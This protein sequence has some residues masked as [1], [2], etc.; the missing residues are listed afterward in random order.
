MTAQVIIGIVFVLIGICV[1]VAK[2]AGMLGSGEIGYVAEVSNLGFLLLGKEL[3]NKSAAAQAKESARKSIAPVAIVLLLALLPACAW[4]QET[5]K[6]I[7]RTVVEVARHL[8]LLTAE[9]QD[10]AALDG[11]T[12]ADFC[13]AE[14]NLRPFIDEVLAAKQRASGKAGLATSGGESP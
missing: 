14:E 4:W 3:L 12:P 11:M 7:V 2:A 6:P 5:G 1:E 8:C 9:E 10:G 13:A